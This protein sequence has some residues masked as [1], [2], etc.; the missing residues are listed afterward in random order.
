MN[1][2]SLR[3]DTECDV[4]IDAGQADDPEAVADIIR[5]LR[6]DLLAEHLGVSAE[7]VGARIARDGSLIAAIDALRGAGRSLISY[8]MPALSDVEKWLAES[9]LL[10]PEGPEEIFKPL[11]ER[12]LLRRLKHLRFRRRRRRLSPPGR[13]TNPT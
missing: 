5:M 3:L 12:G 6:D 13:S 1:N 10:D 2:R 7:I 9:E 11:S 4:A 8:K